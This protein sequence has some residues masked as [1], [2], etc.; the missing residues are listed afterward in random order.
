MQHDGWLE[1]LLQSRFPKHELVV[2]QPRLLRRRGGRL[3]RQ[4]G[5]QQRLR[6]ADFGSS[7]EWLTRTKADVVFAFFGYNESFAGAEG[8]DQFKKDLDSV[9]QA[10]PRPEVQ[11]QDRSAAGPV[12]AH[13]HEN[14]HD[15][16]LPDGVENNKRLA[17]YTE[18]MAEV[19]KAN[20][21]PFVD[22]FKPSLELYAKAA[23]PLTINGVHLTEDG[24]R[25]L[26]AG[27]RQALFAGKPAPTRDAAALEKLRQ[28]VL[29]KNFNWFNRYRTVDGYSIYGGRADLRFAPD[30]RPTAWWP[31]REM[32]VLDVMTANRD[33]RIWAVAQGSDLKVDDSDTPPFIPVKTNKPGTGPNGAHIFLG[34]EEAI[35][36]MTVAKGMKVNLFASEKE[37]PS[38]PSRCRCRSTRRAG[39]GSPSGRPIRTGSPRRR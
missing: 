26:A 9:H 34:G 8:L 4:A 36:N 39:S 35:K 15:R 7:D 16:N 3:H 29:D 30:N 24:D 21:V 12:L 20:H 33:K 31:Q 11:R 38:W 10:H 27:H 6:S 13:R 25:Q 28:A 32:E 37:F 2:P 22:L 23:K 1:T 19:A 18:A 5:L 14:L 17:L